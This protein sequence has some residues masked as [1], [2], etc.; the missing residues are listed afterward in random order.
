[1]GVEDKRHQEDW[2]A[3]LQGFSEVAREQ[4]SA[5][6]KPTV[7]EPG[8]GYDKASLLPAVATTV[9]GESPIRGGTRIEIAKGTPVLTIRGFGPV[10]TK[11]EIEGVFTGFSGSKFSVSVPILYRDEIQIGHV[12]IWLASKDLDKITESVAE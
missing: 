3:L 10:V 4:V 8:Y 7:L 12:R 11:T 6:F 1:M 5:M 9:T 2:H